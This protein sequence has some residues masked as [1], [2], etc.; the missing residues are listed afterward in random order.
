VD[1][2]AWET[3]TKSIK[4]STKKSQNYY[5]RR[6]ISHCLTKV[7]E[8]VRSNETSKIARVTKSKL[9]KWGK[10]EQYKM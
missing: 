2:R 3:I 4:I 5:E 9:N 8:N 1:I 7:F 6:I 10:L